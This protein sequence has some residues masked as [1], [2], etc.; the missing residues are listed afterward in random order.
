MAVDT[1]TQ[2][3]PDSDMAAP[4]LDYL[5]LIVPGS[6]MLVGDEWMTMEALLPCAT[7]SHGSM[8]SRFSVESKNWTI[9]HLRMDRPM[10]IR[11]RITDLHW[12]YESPAGDV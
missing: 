12:R 1:L 7:S 5:T 9:V 3:W 6:Q 2:V 8:C 4:K 11:H 10:W